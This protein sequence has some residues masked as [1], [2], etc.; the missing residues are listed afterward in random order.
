L[1]FILLSAEEPAVYE[2]NIMNA[3]KQNKYLPYIL[4][5]VLI[6]YVIAMAVLIWNER[7]KKKLWARRG[8]YRRKEKVSDRFFSESYRILKLFP[9]TRDYIEKLSYQFRLISP[10]DSK[11]IARKTV[12]ICLISSAIS[13]LIFLLIYLFNPKL[14]TL[15]ITAVAIVIINNEIVGR[16]AKS[17]EV[18]VD[19]ETQ[20]LIECQIHN[21]YVN[22][23]VDDALYLSM[24]SLS[25]NMKVAADQIYQLL[26]SDDREQALTEY[27]ENIPNKFLREF[28]SL[29]VG[30]AERGDEEVNGKY[31][32]IKN[33]EN[34]YSQLEIE[35]DKL[36]RLNMEFTGVMII[37][38]L[39][40]FCIDIVKWFCISI[41][42]TMEAFYY[43]KTGFLMDLGLLFATSSIYIV[44]HK[45]AEY[46][47]FHQSS[48][49]W[50]FLL[51]KISLI[52]RAMNN[53]V[54]KNAS[55]LEHLK[56]ELKNN[57]YNISPRHFIL[58]NFIIAITVFFIGVGIVS[59]LDYKSR[60]ALLV[61]DTAAVSLLTS[62]ADEKQY[63][64]MITTIED[65]TKK[66]VL[67]DDNGNIEKTPETE[68]ELVKQLESEKLFYNKLI[69]KA[70][71]KEILARVNKYKNTNY[72]FLDLF[73]CILISVFSYFIPTILLKYGATVSKDA[74]E[75]EVNQFNALI[76]MLMYDKSITVKKILIEMESYA[77]VF[78][79]S[80]RNCINDYG[81]GDIKALEILKEEEPYGPFGRIVDN[82]IRSD[83][84]PIYEAFHEV[85]VE[86]D[87]YLS[88]RKLANEKAIR[89]RV[90]R[91]YFLVAIPLILLFAYG[92]IPTLLATVNEISEVMN[93]LD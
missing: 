58:R 76:G 34:L 81:S 31:M 83:D 48:H 15:I 38:I 57:G 25:P 47:S 36:Q 72:S 55:K 54:D 66:Y 37:V 49:K 87:G 12:G 89:K 8:G 17:F 26:L 46:M 86:R 9:V 56:R 51:D 35:I 73:I 10:S 24:E 53:Y 40:I 1:T 88:K 14:I 42:E 39:P 67:E 78:R 45:S 2:N 62:A 63:E 3:L 91:A 50:L 68:E 65:Y 82:L 21:Y 20:Q 84:M 77:V 28:V 11:V 22:Y 69:N 33:L 41:K 19:L 23:R 75:D 5:T 85:D 71:A 44:M 59:F 80:L 18:K 60:E 27:Y 30:V 43:G 74:M 4:V 52:K 32:F 13:I 7:E 93:A 79:H 29:C 92:V 70:L 61:S 90:V 64:K 16:M 6:I